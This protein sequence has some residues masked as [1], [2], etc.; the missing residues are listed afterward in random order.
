M[1]TRFAILAA[2]RDT[3]VVGAGPRSDAKR[4]ET[5]IG[6]IHATA[7]IAMRRYLP[8]A[9]LFLPGG[10]FVLAAY[11]AWRMGPGQTRVDD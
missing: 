6:A 4:G 1:A 3:H 8:F 11:V 9:L 7:P 10:T 2:L 5:S